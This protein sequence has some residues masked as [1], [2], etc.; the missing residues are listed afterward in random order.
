MQQPKAKISDIS[1][2]TIFLIPKD[3]DPHLEVWIFLIIS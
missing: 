3:D 2:S 1:E